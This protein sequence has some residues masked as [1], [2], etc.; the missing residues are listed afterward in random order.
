MKKD[1][2]LTIDYGTQ[3]V[4]VSIVDD[5]GQLTSVFSVNYGVRTVIS[6]PPDFEVEKV[7]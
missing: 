3:S 1:L 7:E 5:K 6:L 4:R 2:V